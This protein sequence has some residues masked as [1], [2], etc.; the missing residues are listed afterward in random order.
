[1][2][3]TDPE[4]IEA[5]VSLASLPRLHVKISHTW[6]LSEQEYPWPD[7]HKLVTT[8][9]SAFGADRCMFA[10]DWPVCMMPAWPGG[11]ATYAQTVQLA[12]EEYAKLLPPDDLAML[13]GGTAH[14]IWFRS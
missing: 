2:S 9:V 10:T 6:A 12:K 3:P 13:L 5:L 14:K 1:V 4:Q 8:L 11:G 7:V